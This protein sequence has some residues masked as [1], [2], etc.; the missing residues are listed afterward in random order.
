[1][2]DVAEITLPARVENLREILGFVSDAC[3]QAGSGAA[4]SHALKLAVEEICM[5]VMTH[6][7]DGQAPGPITVTFRARPS[8]LVVTVADRASVFRPREAPEPDTSEGWET[9]P[10][11]GLGWYLVRQLVDDVQHDALPD[12]GNRVTLVKKRVAG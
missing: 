5:N 2:D 8:E 12:G 9:R 1:V 11:G 3:Q 10:I 7:Y 6:G 4:E